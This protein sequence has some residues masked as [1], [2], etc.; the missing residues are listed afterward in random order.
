[1]PLPFSRR[2]FQ[3]DVADILALH[4]I[5]IVYSFSERVWKI[6]S[7]GEDELSMRILEIFEMLN[8]LKLSNSLTQYIH[9]EK[10]KPHGMEHFYPLLQAIK[11]RFVIHLRY[12]KFWE[13]NVSERELEGYVL[14]EFKGRW[15]LVAKDQ[16][17]GY[18][19]TYGLD[20]IVSFEV[21][22]KKFVSANFDVVNFF[23]YCFGII[24][25]AE[26]KPPKI[27]LSFT[28]EQGKYIKS[29]PLHDSQKILFDNDEELRIELN[30]HPTFD[31]TM[32]L[33][34]HGEDVEVVSPAR[35]RRE[36][37]QRYSKALSLY[38][39]SK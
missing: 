34:S 27:I 36:I 20:R 3:R 38:T 13:D 2:N 1:M 32:E 30:L 22:R 6:E 4:R 29:F 37:Q 15:Y 26:A 33:L 9:F 5:N 35:L 28:P 10:R 8:S 25:P 18:I 39:D 7:D 11:K 24:N 23:K 19:K 12:Q 14:K 17:D 21:S 16:H 31:F